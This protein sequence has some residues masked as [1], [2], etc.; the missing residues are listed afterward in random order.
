MGEGPFQLNWDLLVTL[1]ITLNYQLLYG[2]HREQY[3]SVSSFSSVRIINKNFCL[4]NS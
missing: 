2:I 4:R 1:V 3:F